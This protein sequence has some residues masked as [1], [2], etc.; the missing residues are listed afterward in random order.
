MIKSESM[1]YI[2]SIRR[3][4]EYVCSVNI[5]EICVGLY[6]VNLVMSGKSQFCSLM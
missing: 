1:L 3:Q 5:Q 2:P 4:V 6:E